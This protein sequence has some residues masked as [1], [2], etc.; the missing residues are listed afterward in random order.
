MGILNDAELLQRS[1][2]VTRESHQIQ[3]RVQELEKLLS[4]PAPWS[5]DGIAGLV[6][7]FQDAFH[8]RDGSPQ[9]HFMSAAAAITARWVEDL[10]LPGTIPT[11][12][13]WWRLAE[14]LNLHV[15]VYPPQQAEI[16]GQP[17]KATLTG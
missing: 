1:L 15:L 16:E 4:A 11:E 5:L 7:D 3:Q 12:E 14:R 9:S 6:E 2:E 17:V 10:G 13:T 8:L